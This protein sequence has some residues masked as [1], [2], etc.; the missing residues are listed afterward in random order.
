MKAANEREA[1]GQTVLHM[2]LGEPGGGA[3]QPVIE[4]ARGLLRRCGA[5]LGYTEALGIP[6]LRQ[7]IARRYGEVYGVDLE[8]GRVIVTAGS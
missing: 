1:A 7:R 8:P 5:D 6:E 2:E 4:A 3:P